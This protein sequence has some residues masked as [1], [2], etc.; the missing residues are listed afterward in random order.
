[1][2]KCIAFILLAMALIC[3]SAFGLEFPELADLPETATDEM[4]AEDGISEVL[5]HS[6]AAAALLPVNKDIP[7]QSVVA[8]GEV[9]RY[10]AKWKG[11]PVAEARLSAKRVVEL[12]GKPVFVFELTIETN[13]FFST[14]Y[15]T[16]TSIHSY[17]DA[18]SGRS[19]LIRRRVAERNR[20]YRDRLEFKYDNRLANGVPDPV[21]VYS[22]VDQQGAEHVNPPASITANMQDMVSA[23]YYLRGAD[24]GSTGSNTSIVLGGR[25]RPSIATLHIVGTEVLEVPALG[26]PTECIV[27]EPRTDGS[28]ISGNLVATRGGE[29]VW[30]TRKG[31]IPVRIEAQLPS[32]IGSVVATLSQADGMLLPS[33]VD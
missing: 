16:Q 28:N 11:L 22:Y 31:H 18:S 33:T 8:P 17:A 15:P 29:K 23:I 21:S 13:D 26:G 12:R 4:R 3:A 27:V 10:S 6:A 25:K 1:M 2:K 7:L 5:G 30:L 14:I 19:C 24:L 9:L 32:P 20:A